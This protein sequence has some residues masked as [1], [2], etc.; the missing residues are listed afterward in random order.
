MGQ[1]TFDSVG[2]QMRSY[3]SEK[4]VGISTKNAKTITALPTVSIGAGAFSVASAW[5][6]TDGYE[7]IACTVAGATATANNALI[8]WSNDN[9]NIHG[10]DATSI[11]NTTDRF[12]SADLGRTRARYVRILVK[13]GD[14]VAHNFSAYFYLKV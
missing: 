2:A 12:R 3:N 13:N 10:E 4:K 5:F 7:S 11:P 8:Q 1:Q 9:I 6:D 14:T